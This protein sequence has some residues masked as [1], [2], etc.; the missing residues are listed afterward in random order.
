MRRKVASANASSV[1]SAAKVC[2]S[3]NDLAASRSG[4][5]GRSSKPRANCRTAKAWPPKSRPSRST[6]VAAIW[7]T[8]ANPAASSRAEVFGP[9]PGSHL[10]ASGA[11]NAASSPAG[12]SANAAGLWSLEAIWLTSLLLAMPSLTLILRVWRMA[13]RTVVATSRAG[14]DVADRS[15]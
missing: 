7:A 10:L 3:L 14:L 4:T 12:T 8:L 11:R 9:M 2:C 13:S 6:G 5:T 1:T 15:K